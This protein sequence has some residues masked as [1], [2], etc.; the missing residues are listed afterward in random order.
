[1]SPEAQPAAER[2]AG[3]FERAESAFRGREVEPVAGRYHLYVSLA[4]PWAHRTI[5]V[6]RLK[7]LE[8]AI[9]MTVV[10]PL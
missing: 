7:G 5:I 9:G 3:R 2:R 8:D 6:R 1:M 10:D 4:C